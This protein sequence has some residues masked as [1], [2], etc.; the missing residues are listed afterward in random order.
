MRPKQASLSS[1]WY[2]AAVARN[3][4]IFHS[5]LLNFR[6]LQAFRIMNIDHLKLSND[7]ASFLRHEIESG[8]TCREFNG[9]NESR[10][11]EIFFSSLGVASDPKT[12]S[13][14]SSRIMVLDSRRYDM[15]KT[16]SRC[17]TSSA[18]EKG[19]S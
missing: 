5:S 10:D 14:A 16:T 9:T 11:T 8:W 15:H 3:F 18:T 6:L 1:E 13:S 19:R 12:R 7:N 4:A 2:F 17:I